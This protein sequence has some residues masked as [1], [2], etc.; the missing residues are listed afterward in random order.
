M[1]AL[2]VHPEDQIK[3]TLVL[4]EENPLLPLN[5]ALVLLEIISL[6]LIDQVLVKAH[7]EESNNLLAQVLL[8]EMLRSHMNLVRDKVK[9]PQE[10]IKHLTLAKVLLEEP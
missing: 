7:H 1:I 9:V 5:Q 10:E 2:R 4:L 3:Q 8:E 6:V